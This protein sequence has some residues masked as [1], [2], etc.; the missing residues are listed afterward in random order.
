[1]V[2]LDIGAVAVW[3]ATGADG[4]FWPIWVFLVSG[5]RLVRDAWRLLGPGAGAR[6]RFETGHERRIASKSTPT[7]PVSEADLE[8]QRTIRALIE[9]RR[10]SD[11][12]LAEE[13][14]AD[15]AGSS[16]LHWVVDPLD[17][18]V[19][20]LYGIAQWSVSV[21][22]RDAQGTLAGVVH[23]PMAG[24]T[25]AAVRGRAA[26]RNGVPLPSRAADAP[27]L[28]RSLIATGFAYD[29]RVRSQQGA[30]IARLLPLARDIRRAGSAALDLAGTAIGRFDAYFERGV[31]VWDIAAGV[32]VCACT[33]LEVREIADGILVAPPALA[34]ALH[35]VVASP[36]G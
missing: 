18:T 22:V 1:M 5:L 13:E 20:F 23:D 3:A 19:N 27:P 29:A 36:A 26:T 12:F 16:G 35:A 25:F 34:D 4:S 21:A 24:E 10:P 8:S 31:K 17:G 9:A 28:A 33:G 14:G 15:V 2:I 7:D 30:V 32:L 11:A 6:R